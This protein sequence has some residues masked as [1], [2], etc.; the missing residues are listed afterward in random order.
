M[1]F[2]LK[3]PARVCFGSSAPHVGVQV[4][5]DESSRWNWSSHRHPKRTCYIPSAGAQETENTRQRYARATRQVKSGK[6]SRTAIAAAA[7]RAAH[8]HLGASAYIHI[9]DY[10]QQLI[11]IADSKQ[12]LEGLRQWNT[13]S[14]AR[15]CAYFALRHRFAEDQLRRSSPS[16][17]FG[18]SFCSAQGA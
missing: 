5:P 2:Q 12:L 4:G 8:L 3:R 16:A 1:T 7:A 14:V 10:A 13:P 18:R 11:G 17:V 15:V 9:D 6:P